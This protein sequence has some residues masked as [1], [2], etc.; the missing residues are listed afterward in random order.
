VSFSKSI[1]LLQSPAD[2]QSAA[3]ISFTSTDN[4]EVVGSLEQLVYA[5]APCE[6][7]GKKQHD[8]T[9]STTIG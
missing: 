2:A 5:S 6:M 3:V 7:N 8:T 9:Q 1:L 4:I